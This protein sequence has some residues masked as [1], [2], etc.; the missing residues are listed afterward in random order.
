MMTDDGQLNQEVSPSA[1][2][3][4]HLPAIITAFASLVLAIAAV[5]TAGRLVGWQAAII[6]VAFL[7]ALLLLARSKE[8][9]I[10]R[11]RR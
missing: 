7:A 9:P 1:D 6:I 8:T 3:D 4:G 5:L 10:T 2:D 11:G